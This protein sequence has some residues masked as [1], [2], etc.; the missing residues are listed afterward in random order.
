MN[1]YNPRFSA[2]R[3]SAFK[4]CKQK[5][6]LV[7]KDQLVVIGKAS[8]VIEKGLAFHSIAEEMSS[9]KT[10]ED[11]FDIAVGIIDEREF[12]KE[13]Y[14]VI[15]TI[16]RLV[17][18]WDTFV[19][20][21]EDEGYVVKKECWYNDT[22]AGV[23][24]TGAVDCLIINEKEKK[25]KIID[26]KTS[27]TADASSYKNQLIFYAYLVGK[28]L[29]LEINEI[30]ENISTYIFFPLVKLDKDVSTEKMKENTLKNCKRVLFTTEDIES[31]LS[32]FEFI[33]EEDARFDWTKVDPVKDA[34]ITHMCNFCQFLGH[35]DYCPI[36]YKQ[37]IY[38]PRSSKI[39]TKEEAKKLT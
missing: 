14:P 12:D 20:P 37:G 3:F 29:G 8:D 28:Q 38:F 13:K 35:P 17:Y 7:Y 27:S 10:E 31:V 16:P 30:A 23:P 9:N 33:V 1:K 6:K 21:L 39:M 34:K 2:S 36:T 4:G 15:K 11:L 25:A 22:F 19:K 26:Y 5:Y 32:E 24:V 18:W